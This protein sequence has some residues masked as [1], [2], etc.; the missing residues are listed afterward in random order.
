MLAIPLAHGF[1]TS[2]SFPGFL[3]RSCFFHSAD[4]GHGIQLVGFTLLLNYDLCWESEFL[5]KT[6]FTK[7]TNEIEPYRNAEAIAP[8]LR[9]ASR[10]SREQPGG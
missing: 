1:R 2:R 5:T 6:I 3:V 10:D 7:E 4:L 8:K 9:T